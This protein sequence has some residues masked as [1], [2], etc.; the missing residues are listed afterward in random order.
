MSSFNEILSVYG[1]SGNTVQIHGVSRNARQVYG[2]IVN[3][4]QVEFHTFLN[5]TLFLPASMI[6]A[7]CKHFLYPH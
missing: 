4:K 3:A 7:E 2:V 5:F 6:L 1:V